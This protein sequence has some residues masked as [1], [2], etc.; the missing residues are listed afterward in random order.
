MLVFLFT[1]L[2]PLAQARTLSWS[3]CVDLVSKNNPDLAT[4]RSNLESTH[5]LLGGSYSGFLPS[6]NASVNANY[7]FP[8]STTAG[9]STVL[10]IPENNNKVLYSSSLLLS[11]NL[12]SGLKDKGLVAQAKANQ[13][14]SQANLDTVRAQ[15]SFNLRQAFITLSYAKEYVKLTASIQER[16]IQ[17]ERLVRSQ[18]ESGQENQ[19]SYLLSQSLEEQ[20]NYDRHQADDNYQIAMQQLSHLL[21]DDELEVDIKG[22]VPTEDPPKN[23]QVQ[24]LLPLTPIHRKQVGQ[25][26]LENANTEVKR[27]GYFPSLDFSAGVTNS[28]NVLYTDSNQQWSM[29]LTLSIPLFSGFSTYHSVRSSLDLERSA[30]STLA[31]S[32][33]N[34]LNQLRQS[35][36]TYQEAIHKL[37]AD[38]ASL[39]ATTVQEKIAKQQYNNGL[40]TFENWDII[41]ENLISYQK[42]QLASQRDRVIA[43][44]SWRQAQ[45]LG[46]LP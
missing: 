12:F 33:L 22:E 8:S 3:D 20:A 28:S 40:L 15:V 38:T 24:D 21:G 19:G 2:S 31:S 23:I 9:N 26:A 44:S 30:N 25:I 43:E 10:V 5:E 6:V 4:A 18:F 14:I 41:E 13:I 42:T 37:K 29:G 17:N 32:D 45:G 1:L 7:N 39:N 34:T 36:F 27:S 35:F 11:Y 46:D 16:R